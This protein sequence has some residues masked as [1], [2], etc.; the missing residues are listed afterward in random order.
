[1]SEDS[2]P[3]LVKIITEE[4]REK[5]PISFR[6]FMDMALYYPELGYYASPGEKL[7]RKGDFYT[8]PHLTPVFGEMLGRQLLEIGNFLDD[9]DFTVVEMGAGKGLLASDILNFLKEENKVFYDRIN[10]RI[11]EVS[12]YLREIQMEAMKGHQAS[13][14]WS[15]DDFINGIK[16]VF[17]S[18]ELVDS[19]PVHQIVIKDMRLREV[20]V[21]YVDGQFVE[22]FKDPSTDSLQD[23]FDELGVSLPEGYR[24]EVNLDAVR[25]IEKIRKILEK[26]FVVTIDYGY[27]SEE[28]YQHYRSRG[29]LMC[30]YKHTA[31]EDPYIRVGFQDI[32]SHVNFS[33][34]IHWGKKE[35]LE[36]T[37]FTSQAHFLINMGIDEYLKDL[38][39]ESSDYQDYLKRMLPIKNLLMPGMGEAFKVLIQHKGIETPSLKGLS[40][41]SLNRRQ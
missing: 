21:D 3:D 25:W 13:W 23:Y 4:I 22:V 39:G 5:G 10:Y 6:V 30:Y 33:A 20:F 29:T 40:S 17:I 1:M 2:N 31:S 9:G 27:L 37:G 34:L 19:F 32:T 14:H 18:N 41:P 35:G 36:L 16:G 38:A 12:P 7:G 11:I 26:G 24:T 28:L 15:L 8:S